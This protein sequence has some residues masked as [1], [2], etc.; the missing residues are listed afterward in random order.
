LDRG[1]VCVCGLV[2]WFNYNVFMFFLLVPSTFN[3]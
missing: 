3:V 1:G 2:S